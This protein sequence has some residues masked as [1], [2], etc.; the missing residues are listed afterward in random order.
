MYISW[1]I[2]HVIFFSFCC[3]SAKSPRG[4]SLKLS[5]SPQEDLC[6]LQVCARGACRALGAGPAGKDDDEAGIRLPETLHLWRRLGLC[7]RGVLMGPT[8]AQARTG[9]NHNVVQMQSWDR[10]YCYTNMKHASTWTC[11][12]TLKQFYNHGKKVFSVLIYD[13]NCINCSV[14]G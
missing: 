2:W 12:Y 11:S 13:C 10:N 5:L 7:L 4:W 9:N 6:A 8:W 3:K 1:S 14:M